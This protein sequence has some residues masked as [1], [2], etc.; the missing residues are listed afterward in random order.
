MVAIFIALYAL[1]KAK[2]EHVLPHVST[3]VEYLNIKCTSYNDN[4]I[5]QYVAKI[6]EFTVPLMKS[7]S[8]SIIYSLEGSLTKLL[9][10]SGQLVIHS[11]IACLSAVIRL[12]KNTQLV[13]DVFVRYHCKLRNEKRERKKYFLFY[14]AIVI[15]CQ[16]KILEKP[17]EEFKGSAQLARSIYILGVL[18]K[19]FDIEK[20]EFDDLEV[21]SIKQL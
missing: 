12:S 17:N 20:S 4:V 5:V 10:V 21:K 15:Q 2:P 13:K 14:L 11:S 6:L 18:C 9:L 16:Q 3:I 8:S 1:G 7:A 19:Y